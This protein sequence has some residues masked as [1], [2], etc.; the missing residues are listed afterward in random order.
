MPFIFF[1]CIAFNFLYFY[2]REKNPEVFA[3]LRGFLEAIIRLLCVGCG[4]IACYAAFKMMHS[5]VPHS[6]TMV[7]L[8]LAVAV[9]FIF[10]AFIFNMI[11]R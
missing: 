8:N 3:R 10:Y 4:L 11:K 1:S 5:Q 9:F 2:V 7:I 6:S